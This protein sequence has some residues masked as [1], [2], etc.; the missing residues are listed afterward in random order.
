MTQFTQDFAACDAA[1]I[2]VLG[3]DITFKPPYDA[4]IYA[5]CVLSAKPGS[6]AKDVYSWTD[7]LWAKVD[8]Y[9]TII[10]MPETQAPGIAKGWKALFNDIEYLVTEIYRKGDGTIAVVLNQPGNTS[11]LTSA[12]K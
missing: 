8:I 5:H 6:G 11:P 9:S 2:T 12:W 3:D 1:I 4:Y 10:E 7:N